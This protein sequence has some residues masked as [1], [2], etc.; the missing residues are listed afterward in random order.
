MRRVIIFGIV[1][2]FSLMSISSAIAQD[3]PVTLKWGHHFKSDFFIA[4]ATQKIVELVKERTGGKFIIEVYPSAQ[5][6]GFFQMLTSTSQGTLDLAWTEGGN[7]SRLYPPCGVTGGAYLFRSIRHV[8]NFWDS[9][10]GLKIQQGMYDQANLKAFPAFQYGSR[11]L[12]TS[13]KMVKT[14]EDLKG[15]RIRS[16]ENRVSLTNV[17]ALG[18]NPSPVDYSELYMALQQGIVDGQENP[19][20]SIFSMKFYEVQ[21]YLFFTNHNHEFIFPVM[22]SRVWERLPANYKKIFTDAL[23]EV[24]PISEKMLADLTADN[25]KSMTARGLQVHEVNVEAFRNFAIPIVLAEF[26]KDWFP[27]IYEDIKKVPD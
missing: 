23:L 12:T 7:V 11:Q 6:G 22:N 1:M 4:V 21:K 14:P 13:K 15:V 26:G 18:A 10:V 19:I 8:Q 25:L 3:K 9:P 24:R 5:L 16:L 2:V 17:K 27:N 20:P